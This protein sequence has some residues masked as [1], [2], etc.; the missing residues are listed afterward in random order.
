[1]LA[2]FVPDRIFQHIVMFASRARNPRGERF[3]RLKSD[4]SST[5]KRT[6]IMCEVAIIVVILCCANLI[7]TSMFRGQFV[8][9]LS[10][11]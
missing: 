7:Q 9:H 8:E 4:L 1:M 6:S 2:C 10:Y 11:I 5:A 3:V